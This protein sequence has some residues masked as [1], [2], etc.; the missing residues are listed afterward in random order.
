MSALRL[1]AVEEICRRGSVRAADVAMLQRAL[2][3]PATLSATDAEALFRIHAATRVQDATW[4]DFFIDT[5]TDYIVRELEPAGYVTSGHAG[6]LIARVSTAGRVRSKT[7]HDL[8]L[9][10]ID[11]ARWVP[12]SLMVFAMSQVRDAVITGGGPLRAAG[13]GAA[14]QIALAEIEQFRRLLFSYGADGAAALTGAE[15]DLLIDI[16]DAL[17][18]ALPSRLPSA[19]G[20][21][22][23]LR[24][25]DRQRRARGIG[26]RDAE[27][28]GGAA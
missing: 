20:L 12:E 16:D 10:I 13:A 23:S 5:L 21:V 15:V 8:L 24:Q 9:N 19:A 18:Q 1:M 28:R 2:A 22:R 6:W 4:S 14:G 7:E 11:K 3:R 26:L 17:T 27:P 25:G